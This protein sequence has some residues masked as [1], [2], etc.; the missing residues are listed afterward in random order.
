MMSSPP[1]TRAASVIDTDHGGD[2]ETERDAELEEVDELMETS[3]AMREPG[4]IR[5]KSTRRKVAKE[6]G[7][8]AIGEMEIDG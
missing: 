7:D 3:E 1:S 8:G 5:R 2:T 6:N 4:N